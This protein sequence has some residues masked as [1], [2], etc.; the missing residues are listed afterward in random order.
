MLN[1]R[2]HYSDQTRLV[3]IMSE[4]AVQAAAVKIKMTEISKQAGAL[5]MGLQNA[6]PS[7]APNPSIQYLSAISEQL[8]ELVEECDFV[9]NPGSATAAN[10]PTTDP[11][12]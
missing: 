6:S 12:K 3:V 11:G 4:I 5:A 7:D 8:I 10:E 2:R 1:I 9:I